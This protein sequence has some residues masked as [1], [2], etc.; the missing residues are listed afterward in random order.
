MKRIGMSVCALVLFAVANLHSVAQENPWNGNWKIDESSFKY[1]GPT[2]KL[3][4]SP[5]GFMVT[6]DGVAMPKMV[7]DGQPKMENG[8]ETTCT[9]NDDGYTIATSK[10]SKPESKVTLTLSADGKTSTR[11]IEVFPPNGSPYTITSTAERVGTGKGLAGE[12]KV[13]DFKESQDTGILSIKVDGDMVAFKETDTDKPVMCKLD[14]TPT[15]FDGRSMSVKLADPHTLKVTYENKGKVQRENTFTL[16]ADG[17]T[18]TEVDKT[19]EPSPST[20]S[21]MFHKS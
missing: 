15:D 8:D 9:K 7:C 10:D 14:G 3:A 18:V 11:R 17:S 5:D 20:T 1:E 2:F 12:W 13:T 16:S 19:P 4:T 6:R 21:M